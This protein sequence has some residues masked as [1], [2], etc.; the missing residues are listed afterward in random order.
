MTEELKPLTTLTNRQLG[1]QHMP[2]DYSISVANYYKGGTDHFLLNPKTKR[3][4]P[5]RGFDE[6]YT[7]IIDY[8]VRITHRIWEEYNVGLIYDYYRH[9]S[10]VMD[11][12]AI[13]HGRETIVEN[14]IM[15][16]NAFPDTR[17][18]ADEIIWAGNEDVGFHTSHRAVIVGHNTG[19]TQYGPP[20][21]KKVTYWVIAD[22]L[23]IENEIHE[24]W[25]L[26]NTTS[27]MR[28]LG[29]DIFQQAR[30]LQRPI[31][32]RGMQDPRSG[33]PQ[34]LPGLGKPPV[35]PPATDSNFD[36]EDFVRRAFHE[37]W[38]WR[39]LGKVNDYYA[40]NV[41]FHGAGD[42]ELRGTGQ[43]RSYFMSVLAM[44]PNLAHQID[45]IYWMGNVQEGYRVSVRWS[46]DGA[47]RGPGLYGKP[48]GKPISMWGISQLEI[49]NGKILEEWT[50]FNEFAVLQ[51]I[52]AE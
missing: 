23:S 34:R 28:Q 13:I 24:E 44:F 40:P 42:R 39:L 17:G 3:T 12:Y 5:M 16:I 18:Y 31:D 11:D 30:K 43:L 29:L 4:Q 6:Q 46:V 52:L 19:F 22:C 36:V 1:R 41:R 2:K 33:E 25:V 8:I 21:N 51:Q 38:N 50:L 7:D 48:T 37:I 27:V 26:Y 9:N 35:L 15:T 49:R 32:Q 10:R 45:H 14:T 47:H 20:T